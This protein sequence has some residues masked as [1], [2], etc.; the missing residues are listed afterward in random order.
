MIALLES[1]VV[2]SSPPSPELEWEPELIPDLEGD[3]DYLEEVYPGLDWHP[4]WDSIDDRYV[5]AIQVARNGG[6]TLHP[7]LADL[8]E[9]CLLPAEEIAEYNWF[10][11]SGG[12]PISWNG[13]SNLWRVSGDVLVEHVSGDVDP[14]NHIHI[15]PPSRSK[16][17]DVLRSWIRDNECEVAAAIALEPFDPGGTLDRE[18]RAAWYD[19]LRELTMSV[20]LSTDSELERLL[21]ERLASEHP[22]AEV[23]HAI[24]EPLTPDGE[25]MNRLLDRFYE[26]GVIGDLIRFEE[27]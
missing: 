17:A 10:S 14:G 19:K 15:W 5:T 12:A 1:L 16:R 6:E 21:R 11:E 18:T 9:G 23:A 24:R 20:S 2:D 7:V 3:R 25:K 26:D 8:R 27:A 22:Y 13:S 4:L